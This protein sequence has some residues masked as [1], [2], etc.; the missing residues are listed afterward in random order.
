MH[1]QV[2]NTLK[3]TATILLIQQPIILYI[4]LLSHI[5]FNHNFYQIYI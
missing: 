1:F 2:K 4:F 5:N 3:K